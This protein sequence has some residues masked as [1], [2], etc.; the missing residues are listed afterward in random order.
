M[1]YA[2][3]L[4]AV[5]SIVDDIGSVYNLSLISLGSAKK[6][7]FV[8]G[9]DIKILQQFYN[10]LFPNDMFSLE[11]LPFLPLGGFTR[12]N[13][14]FGAAKLFHENT[15]DFK[16]FA[17]LDRDFYLDSQINN[18]YEKSKENH[19]ILHVWNRKEL[20]N[21]I[22]IPSVIFK[23][24]QKPTEEYS[25]FI[26][27]YE[28]LVDTFL[29][30]TI[31]AYTTKIFEAY[32]G[33]IM[34]GTAAK[35]AREYVNSKWTCLNDKIALVGGKVLL[36]STNSWIKSTYKKSCSMNKIFSLMK[37]TDVDKEIVDV[38]NNLKSR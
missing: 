22:L 15:S 21:Y 36:A 25:N 29:D 24:T 34:P 4:K 9:N 23:I 16:C 1:F 6:C 3:H 11:S 7:I 27:E 14:A 10:V 12:V 30:C 31:D 13:E 2:N 32:N 26:H 5:Q 8:E 20:E 35:E 18:L 28:K 33:K 38:I 17:I 19:L 37:P